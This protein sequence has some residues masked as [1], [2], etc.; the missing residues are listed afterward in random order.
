MRL[1]LAS[2]HVRLVELVGKRLAAEGVV[3]EVRYR[4]RAL[5]DGV[6]GVPAYR[7]LWIESDHKLQ[8]ALSLV[9]MHCEVGRN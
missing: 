4:P 5:G 1:L 7:E 8:W 6:P 3:C 9:A 2:S